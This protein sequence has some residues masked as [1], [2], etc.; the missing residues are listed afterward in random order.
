VPLVPYLRGI[1]TF[2]EPCAGDGALVRYLEG[3]GLRCAYAGDIATGQDALARDSYGA[4]DAIITNPP[5]TREELWA[6]V[7][8]GMKG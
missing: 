7:G 1:G 3:V 4:A 8:D 5:Y 6:K 2:A